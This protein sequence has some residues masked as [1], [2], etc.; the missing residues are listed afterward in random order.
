MPDDS[1]RAGTAASAE[2]LVSA[3]DSEFVALASSC[4][5]RQTDIGKCSACAVPL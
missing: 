1:R 3:P 4:S 5:R 2:A